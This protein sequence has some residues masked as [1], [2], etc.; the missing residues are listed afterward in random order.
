M[1]LIGGF[2]GIFNVEFVNVLRDDYSALLALLCF[3]PSFKAISTCERNKVIV[4]RDVTIIR[5]AGNLSVTLQGC[6]SPVALCKEYIDDN[7]PCFSNYLDDNQLSNSIFHGGAKR[8][9][10]GHIVLNSATPDFFEAIRNF[11]KRIIAF[12]EDWGNR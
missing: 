12:I 7:L 10:E 2:G 9:H 8:D 6:Y 3:D 1:A 5:S 11:K 4:W